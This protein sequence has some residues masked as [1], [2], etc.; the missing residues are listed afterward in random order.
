MTR[1][2][3]KTLKREEFTKH[4]EVLAVVEDLKA[5]MKGKE[6]SDV[7]D[8]E[9]NQYVDIVME[10]GGTLGIAL[11]G[12][13]YALEQ[14]KLRFLDIGGTSAGAI[15]AM[16][17]AAVDTKDKP[18]AERLLEIARGEG[19]QRVH[20]QQGRGEALPQWVAGKASEAPARTA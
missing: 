4:P 13:V 12:Y 10:G 15:N 6:V 1:T 8:A 19:P 5:Y 17:L 18:K 3:E 20:G 9:G 11:L 2:K 14:A 16:L 7:I